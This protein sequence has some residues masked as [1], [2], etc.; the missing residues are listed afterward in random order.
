MDTYVCMDAAVGSAQ[1][2]CICICIGICLSCLICIS[3][4]LVLTFLNTQL[5][6]AELQRVLPS[7]VWATYLWSVVYTFQV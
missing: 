1:N 6:V 2:P 4:R 5:H 3:I 7:D